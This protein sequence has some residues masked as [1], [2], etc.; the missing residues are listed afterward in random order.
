MKHIKFIKSFFVYFQYVLLAGLLTQIVYSAEENKK[1]M[2]PLN[3]YKLVSPEGHIA[4]AIGEDH[5]KDLDISHEVFEILKGCKTIMFEHGAIGLGSNE[6]KGV[7][8]APSPTVKVDI[9]EAKLS[10]EEKLWFNESSE[11]ETLKLNS[12][13]LLRIL[14]WKQYKPWFVTFMYIGENQIGSFNKGFQPLIEKKNS[15]LRSSILK[16]YYF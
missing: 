9:E 13:T 6:P 4:Y 16:K 7:L 15:Q 11:E 3:F 5:T 14:Q 10:K 2:Y 12:H 8:A 1:E